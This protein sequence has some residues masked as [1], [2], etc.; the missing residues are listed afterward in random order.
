MERGAPPAGEGTA[1][2]MGQHHRHRPR[3]STVPRWLPIPVI[4]LTLIPAFHI[5]WGLWSDLFRDTRI[6]GANPIETLEHGLGIWIIRFLLL[7]LAITPVMKITG[8]GWLIR[9]RR[10]F[11]LVAFFYASLHLS[12]YFV[13]DVEL[14][15]NRMVEDVAERLYITL[16]MTAFLMLVPLAVTSTKGWIRRMGNR[17]WVALH[18]LIFPA[19]VLGMTH[20]YL[21]VKRDVR[22]P[23]AYAALLLLLLGWRLNHRR[24]TRLAGR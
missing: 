17:R 20:Y 2:A 3:A 14:S 4:A 7:T 19:V 8:R 24:V 13:L 9:Y 10:I 23:L 1:A 12:V 16:G 6:L 21:A 11:G 18:W 15:W 22:A 5:G